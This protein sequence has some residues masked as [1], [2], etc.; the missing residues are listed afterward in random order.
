MTFS[1]PREEHLAIRELYETYADGGSRLD[2]ETWLGCYAADA[3]WRCP[4]FDHVG[5][6][7]IAAQYDAI[8]IGVTDVT[9][10]I[11][12]GALEVEG[13]RAHCRL[14]QSESLLYADGSTYD[15]VGQY[16]D[17]LVRREGRW[18]FLDR[19][20]TIKRESRPRK[21]MRFSGAEADR[22]AIRELHATY[23]DAASR[24]DK[25]QWLDCFTDEGVWET[26]M[27]PFSGKAALAARWDE[28]FATMDAMLYVSVTGSV[29]VDGDRASA[30]DHVREVARIGGAVMKFAARYDDDCVRIDGE[31]KFARRRYC[32]TLAE[33]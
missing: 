15:L 6:D 29:H 32:M 25:Q 27:G 23:A 10:F 14:Q 18:W 12:I 20:Y 26:S 28:L 11:Q 21:G 16:E 33:Q 8:M 17:E 3:R 5:I 22:I 1:G 19:D 4:Y 24:Q 13:D 31:W 7:P 2:R 30:T 9:F